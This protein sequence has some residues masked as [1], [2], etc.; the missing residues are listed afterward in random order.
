MMRRYFIKCLF[1]LEELNMIAIISPSLTMKNCS[2]DF[3]N[4]TLPSQ[5]DMSKKI[6][7]EIRKLSLEDLE[8]ILCVNSKVGKLN[9]ERYENLKFDEFGSPAILS[10]TGTAYKNIKPSIFN[11]EEIKF[12]SEH[13]RILSGLYGVLKP[14]DSIYEY[15]LELKTRINILGNEDLYKYFG[16]SMYKNLVNCDRKIVNLCSSEYSKAI[17]PYLSHEDEFLTCSFKINKNG[18]LKS[19]ST[20]AKASRGSMINFIVKNKINDFESLK[21]FNDNGYTFDERLSNSTEYVFVK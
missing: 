12:C 17:I 20:D 18:I 21:N 3:F 14:Y 2:D 19:I 13:V 10:Y 7:E 15:R 8:K 4:L 9:F 11:E 1:V 5:I 16:D 6:V